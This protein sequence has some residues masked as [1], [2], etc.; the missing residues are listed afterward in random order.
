M[1]GSDRMLGR[2]SGLALVEILFILLVS[3]LLIGYGFSKWLSQEKVPK[4]KM[5]TEQ[6]QLIAEALD[7]FHQ[8]NQRYPTTE[9]GLAA[10]TERSAR[11]E[12]GEP[13]SYL[14][15]FMATDPWGNSYQYYSPGK[16]KSY[17]LISW[18]ADGKPQGKGED[19]DIIY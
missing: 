19:A 1:L 11:T 8:E 6:M 9:E 3:S 16:E 14:D 13:G 2:Q 12:S 4:T 10:L 5:A 15:K 7:N 17:D 18:G